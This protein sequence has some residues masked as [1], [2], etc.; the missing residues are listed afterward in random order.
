MKWLS[1]GY[2]LLGL[3]AAGSLLVA[4]GQPLVG[5]KVSFAAAIFVGRIVYDARAPYQYIGLPV[6]AFGVG[7]WGSLGGR[8]YKFVGRCPIKSRG[9]AAQAAVVGMTAAFAASATLKPHRSL[10]GV[11]VATM[12][13]FVF[14]L[15]AVVAWLS[16]IGSRRKA[17]QV[18]R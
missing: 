5:D 10:R 17:E 6:C 12:N 15:L 14:T 7:S 18:A 4:I 13:V 1:T 2:G 8:R 11:S 16:C 9:W 3:V